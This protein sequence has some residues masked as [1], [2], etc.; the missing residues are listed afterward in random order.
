MVRVFQLDC[1]LFLGIEPVSR[2]KLEEGRAIFL[3]I[4]QFD[5]QC[6]S[7]LRFL[8]FQTPAKIS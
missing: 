8:K 7:N 1:R 5:R 2:D 6:L 3:G 4:W